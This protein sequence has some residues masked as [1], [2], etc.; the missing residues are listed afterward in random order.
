MPKAMASSIRVHLPESERRFLTDV[1]DMATR[2]LDA[3]ARKLGVP[4]PSELDLRFHP[5]VEA[6]SRATD[7]PWWTAARTTGT[8][9]DL[10]PL[11][12][13]QQ[14]GILEPTLQ[15]EFVHVLAAP[16]LSGRPLWVREGLAVVLAGELTAQPTGRGEPRD[17][18][19][20]ACPPDA[21]LRSP[22]SADAWRRAY[23]AAGRCLSCPLDRPPLARPALK[24]RHQSGP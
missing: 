19:G 10:L 7:Q 17:H 15:H 9:I 5:T 21:D 13:L 11:G 16:V 3:L 12:V 24:I 20:S 4:A 1:Q 2:L 8:Q 18:Y 6:Y 22:T 14:R 23:E